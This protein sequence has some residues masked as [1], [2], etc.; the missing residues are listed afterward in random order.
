MTE[1]YLSFKTTIMRS[2]LWGFAL[3]F[4]T[5]T[6][7][8]GAIDQVKA[9]EVKQWHAIDLQLFSDSIHHARMIF[10]DE[11]PPYAIWQ[12]TQII[13]IAENILAHQYEDGG[14]PKNIDW[15]RAWSDEELVSIRTKYG[16]RQ[17]GTLDN[18]NT[19]SQV[20][21]LAKVHQ[22]TDLNRYA[23]AASKGL[24]WILTKQNE[25]SG[26]WPGD[27]VDAVTFNDDV[28]VGVMKLLW[29]IRQGNKEYAFLSNKLMQRV[30]EAYNRGLTCI[31]KCQ[32]KVQ[33]ELTAWCQQ[34][35]HHDLR[36]V[37]ARSYELPSIVSAESVEVVH[38]LMD[39]DDPIP[40]VIRAVQAAV[41]W[42]ARVKIT[43]LRLKTIEAEPIRFRWHYS[44]K[45]RVVVPDPQ[46]P[47]IWARFY[48]LK[49]FKPFFVNRSGEVVQ[50]YSK[51]SRERRTGYDWYGYWPAKL[52]ED[53]YS[54]WQKKWAPN[55]NV[56]KPNSKH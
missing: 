32:I 4:W 52:L 10:K 14:W 42:L 19:Y 18:R 28:M 21:Y 12:P 13:H 46:T 41:S 7:I 1:L 8:Q 3:F 29:D 50:D 38:F 9:A 11:K 54:S 49:E 15:Q 17:G 47:T 2:A 39:I 22:Q 23:Q 31:L 24:N 5:V 34:H 35:S 48:D 43:G 27:D 33:G 26:G 56:L 44:D 37:K 30:N 51:L 45:D 40:E 20:R 53:E 55:D 6:P 36:P 25:H 16:S